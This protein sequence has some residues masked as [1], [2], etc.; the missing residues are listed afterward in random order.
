MELGLQLPCGAVHRSLP[1]PAERVAR[2]LAETP[3]HGRAVIGLA[4][5]D[6]VAAASPADLAGVELLHGIAPR[7]VPRVDAGVIDPQGRAEEHTR[8][9]PHVLDGASFQDP[10]EVD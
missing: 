3:S 7:D 5:L 10:G 4:I 8:E 2:D 9:N 1:A 6:D